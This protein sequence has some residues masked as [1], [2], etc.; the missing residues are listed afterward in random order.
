MNILSA[1]ESEICVEEDDGQT[2]LIRSVRMFD[3]LIQSERE[4]ERWFSIDLHIFFERENVI[5]FKDKQ[6]IID[7]F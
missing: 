5:F 3:L 2:E 7:L 6:M 1:F 4:R